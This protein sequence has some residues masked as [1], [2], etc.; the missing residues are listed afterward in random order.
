MGR[1]L[2]RFKVCLIV[3][4]ALAV[5]YLGITGFHSLAGMLQRE[6]RENALCTTQERVFDMA[7]VLSDAEEEKLRKLIAKRER[8]TGCDI[9]LV[10]L[11]ESLQEY[12]EKRKPYIAPDKYVMVY[13]DDFYDEHMFGYDGPQGSGVLLLDNL[14]REKDGWAYSWLC[15]T[16]TAERKYSN[17]M[18]GHL[19]EKSYRWSK[20]SPYL[21]YKAYINQFYHDMNG[22]GA[23]NVN[24]SVPLILLI[25]LAFAVLFVVCNLGSST[26]EKTT[27][28]R[29]YVKDGKTR[30][31]RREDRFIRKNI[32]QHKI[33]TGNGGGGGYGSGGGGHHIS[34][35]GASHGGGGHRH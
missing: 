28:P 30:A 12:A 25:S 9:V 5:I 10:T 3:L 11:D 31:I 1:F 26:G 22:F 24:F 35:G 6:E 23:V 20:L 32:V 8:Q 29:S 2:K 14:Y 33:Q 19:L 16:G 27:T 21:G 15:T 7:D 13:A 4:G 17:A 34:G 18:I